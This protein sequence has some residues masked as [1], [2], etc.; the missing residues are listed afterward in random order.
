MSQRYSQLWWVLDPR[1]P[2]PCDDCRRLAAASPYGPPGSGRNELNQTPGDGR[3]SC[4][5][6]CN[7]RLSYTPPETIKWPKRKPRILES[8][9]EDDFE[10]LGL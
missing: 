4:G 9:T 1:D 6:A 8:Y 2:A 5:P 10:R 7:C 3:T